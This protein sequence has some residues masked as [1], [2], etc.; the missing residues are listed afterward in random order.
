MLPLYEYV[1]PVVVFGFI[2]LFYLSHGLKKYI[3]WNSIVSFVSF[4]FF[5]QV[6]S[7]WAVEY[8]LSRGPVSQTTRDVVRATMFLMQISIVA[9]VTFV[10]YAAILVKEKETPQR[11]LLLV[12]LGSCVIVLLAA[13]LLFLSATRYALHS[14]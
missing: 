6:R 3:S 2:I 13:F 14:T 8:H 12:K 7:A 1:I 9:S 4:D 11:N 10:G 5:L